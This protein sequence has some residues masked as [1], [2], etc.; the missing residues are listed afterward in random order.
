M[1]HKSKT[2]TKRLNEVEIAKMLQTEHGRKELLALADALV[3]QGMAD[4][5][6]VRALRSLCESTPLR[7]TIDYLGMFNPM[8]VQ[9]L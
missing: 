9:K 6:D 8:N 2:P 5:E 1:K 4:E 3:S 7:P